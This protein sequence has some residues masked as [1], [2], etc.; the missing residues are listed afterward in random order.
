MS[1]SIS[2]DNRPSGKLIIGKQFKL[3]IPAQPLVVIN[4]YLYK[5]VSGGTLTYKTI[6]TSNRTV[7]VIFYDDAFSDSNNNDDFIFST[8]STFDFNFDPFGSSNSKSEVFKTSL[9]CTSVSVTDINLNQTN[10]GTI[11]WSS[12]DTGINYTNTK[13]YVVLYK[14]NGTYIKDIGEITYGSSLQNSQFSRLQT[15]QYYF[16]CDFARNINVGFSY[17]TNKKVT[18]NFFTLTTQSI[19]SISIVYESHFDI[20]F[21]TANFGD[22]GYTDSNYTLL[23]N[24]VIIRTSIFPFTYDPPILPNTATYTATI[25][26]YSYLSAAFTRYVNVINLTIA[27]K[28]KQ[29]LQNFI[30]WQGGS[31]RESFKYGSTSLFNIDSSTT[32]DDS[33]PINANSLTAGTGYLIQPVESN[34]NGQ[35]YGLFYFDSIPPNQYSVTTNTIKVTGS[36]GPFLSNSTLTWN[37]FYTSVN[38]SP[39]VVREYPVKIGTYEDTSTYN[40]LDISNTNLNYG[41][42]Y[43]IQVVDIIIAT[44]Y[45][46]Y[47]NPYD[48]TIT[49]GY[50]NYP[51]TITWISST[52]PELNVKIGTFTIKSKSPIV[53][54]DLTDAKTEKNNSI[55]FWPDTSSFANGVSFPENTVTDNTFTFWNGGNLPLFQSISFSVELGD[56][57]Y[58]NDAF[59]L[60]LKR[61]MVTVV[62][63]EPTLYYKNG[64]LF[65]NNTFTTPF[66]WKPYTYLA[67]YQANDQL[68][69]KS[70]DHV[71]YGLSSPFTFQANASVTLDNISYSIFSTITSTLDIE[72]TDVPQFDIYLYRLNSCEKLLVDR[73]NEK[74]YQF[75]PVDVVGLDSTYLNTDV[76]LSYRLV[77]SPNF[78][79]IQSPIFQLNTGTVLLDQPNYTIISTI[80]SRVN[81]PVQ[82]IFTVQLIKGSTRN[83]LGTTVNKTFSFEAYPFAKTPYVNTNV[84]L[85][86]TLN[87]SSSITLRSPDFQISSTYFT[88][89]KP[90][91]FTPEFARASS[92]EI[93]LAETRKK[94]NVPTTIISIRNNVAILGTLKDVPHFAVP[95]GVISYLTELNALLKTISVRTAILFIIQKYS[96]P[97]PTTAIIEQKRYKYPTA[98]AVVQYPIRQYSTTFRLGDNIVGP[99]INT[100]PD[101]AEKIYDARR[102]SIVNNDTKTLSSYYTEMLV[103]ATDWLNTLPPLAYDGAYVYCVVRP[104]NGSLKQIITATICLLNNQLIFTP[105]ILRIALLF[106]VPYQEGDITILY[107]STRILDII[108]Y[109]K[110]KYYKIFV[111]D[112]TAL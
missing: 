1:I 8:S 24:N 36:N 110:S 39:D 10:S 72:V 105:V 28:I 15:G 20:Y 34:E 111:D 71:N 21:I 7:D 38:T 29:S 86:F 46:F 108:Y 84:Y 37:A 50:I 12:V 67:D 91:T 40:T 30:S 74:T 57:L 62:V 6:N 99:S 76:Y 95:C 5:R 26:D 87:G 63:L 65:T 42:P 17:G 18:S 19:Q 61:T 4:I 56:Y 2:Q 35:N 27:T 112:T 90:P 47:E 3:S 13:A 25:S 45:V 102:F 41:V 51:N 14:N 92:N 23:I 54:L 32:F 22:Y 106:Y 75:F 104:T 101:L 48:V 52:N 83:E 33:D 79:T 107:S 66:V 96:I 103:N 70:N 60:V 109:L 85:Q 77:N 69:L 58:P 11:T 98:D 82:K 31:T 100:I 80:V 73:T 59:S 55:T 81:I 44:N 9:F 49:P 94:N 64:S 68:Q 43:T 88:L 89:N 53:T 93:C 78:Y 16:I 97:I